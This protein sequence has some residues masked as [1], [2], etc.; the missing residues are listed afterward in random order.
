MVK[1][2]I[3]LLFLITLSVTFIYAQE[4]LT[5]ERFL[6]RV[7]D[8][9]TTIRD[10]EASVTIRSGNTEMVGN[11]IYLSP[12]FLRIDF[13]RPAEQVIV[14]NGEVLTVFVPELRAVLSQNV[15]QRRAGSVGAGSAQGLSMLRRNYV[16]SFVTGPN[17]EP[18]D[19]TGERVVRIRLTRR[20]VAESFREIILSINPDTMM[21][22][23]MEGRTV[24]DGE[25]RLDFTNVRTNVGIP[26][27]RF[28]YDHP[29]LANVYHNFLF[30]DI[31]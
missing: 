2:R 31:D 24:A 27:Q 8:H 7:S 14:F 28:V 15:N 29:G 9:Y 20:S 26:E 12:S 5:A 17:P 21:I 23:R 22:R 6:E 4:L 11:L 10:F 25:V 18:L 13:T 1:K 3:I 30:R 19:G 16:A